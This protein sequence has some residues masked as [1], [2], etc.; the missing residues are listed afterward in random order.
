MSIAAAVARQGLPVTLLESS[1]IGFAASTKN[2]GWL[3]S[4]AW[5]A[6]S[7]AELAGKC[8]QSFQ[9]VI[10]FSPD[11]LEPGH[12][13]MLYF[14]P[15]DGNASE[16]T[17]AWDSVDI[18]WQEV[19]ITRVSDLVPGIQIDAVSH[20]FRLP[21]RSIQPHVLIKDITDVATSS[22]VRI[23]TGVRVSG[24]D[25]DSGKV[26]GVMTS[27]GRRF[28]TSFV[29]VA[30]NADRNE[31][32]QIVGDDCAAE[33]SLYRRVT[34]QGD[35]V[36]TTP[37]LC[38]E[39]FCVMDDDGL[40]HMPHA[41]KEDGRISVFGNNNWR[42]V[43][44]H[45]TRGPCEAQAD[46]I[47]ERLNRF[48]PDV[49]FASSK[50]WCGRTVQAMHVD[51]IEPGQVPLPT[52]IDHSHEA[53]RLSNLISVYPGRASLWPQLASDAVEVILARVGRPVPLTAS[54]PWA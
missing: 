9:Q 50:Q 46:H 54:P 32:T 17:N 47:F 24:F 39:P 27:C 18:P 37:Q 48:F 49:A 12:T 10:R 16:W 14:L 29:V 25:I 13:G 6:R 23:Q 8:W 52:V 15:N 20:V 35:L 44:T 43:P 45:E 31:L 28:E 51:Q 26:K 21:D 36:A 7:N 34:L 2:Q 40:N 42:V 41:N 3:H 38:N 4:G 33:Q 22:A 1:R 19:P 30:T 11:S 53:C 5:F